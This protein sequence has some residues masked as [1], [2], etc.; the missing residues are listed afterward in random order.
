MTDTIVHYRGFG[1]E[2]RRVEAV[3]V[4]G[5]FIHHAKRLW[6]TQAVV[7]D[8]KDIH[9]YAIEVSPRTAAELQGQWA[10]WAEATVP[11]NAVD[12]S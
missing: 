10:T 3:P 6:T 4:A 2:H 8:G 7:L 11:A 9:L 12:T 5:M 1:S